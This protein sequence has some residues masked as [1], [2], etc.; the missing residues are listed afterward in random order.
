MTRAVAHE[1]RLP[2]STLI[3][4]DVS[5]SM[6]GGLG[7]KSKLDRLD[8]AAGLA[9]LLRSVSDEPTIFATAGNDGTQVHATQTLPARNGMALRDAIKGTYAR[10]GGG[11]IFL[12]QALSYV[13]DQGLTSFDRV[14]VITDEQD[15]DVDSERAPDRA[16]KLGTRNYILNVGAYDIGLNTKSY[17]DVVTGFSEAAIRYIAFAEA[18]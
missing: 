12:T 6:R 16:P 17:W 1:P 11:G 18:Q 13:R 4:V 9:I 2:G 14:V 3:L 8:A 10:L 15:C 5:G 7:G